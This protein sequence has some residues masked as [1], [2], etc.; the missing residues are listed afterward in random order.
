MRDEF[1]QDSL[2]PYGVTPSQL[3]DAQ[4]GKG[5]ETGRY[6]CVAS[7]G[8]VNIPSAGN[9]FWRR[10][11]FPQNIGRGLTPGGKK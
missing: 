1:G 10:L 6:Y 11:G 2:L 7:P 3:L 8:K 5:A 9:S 4:S